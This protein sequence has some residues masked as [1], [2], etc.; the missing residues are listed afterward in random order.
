M[1]PPKGKLV[2]ISGPSG[3]GKSTVLKELIETCPLPLELSVSATTRAPRPEERDGVE[4]HFLSHEE[5]TRRREQ[6]EFLECKEVYGRG[7]WYG[8]LGS[9]VT[10]GLNQG[11]WVVLEIDVEGALAV[12]EKHPQTITIFL[13]CGGLEELERRL[14][15]RG[16]EDEQT[17]NRRLDVAR[18]EI[19]YIHHYRHE[20]TNDTVSQAVR[21]IC[22]ILTRY[23]PSS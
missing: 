15:S 1:N 17:V 7:D 18:K 12:L 2:I 20:V 9:T 10:A 13:H 19:T 8:T 4:Y 14:R 22:D 11:K 21:D 5:F 3:A 6:G 16:T 23:E